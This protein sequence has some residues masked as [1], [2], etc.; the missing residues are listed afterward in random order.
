[1]GQENVDR[2]RAVYSEWAEGNFRA[3]GELLAPESV[4]E[5]MSDGR[6]SYRGREAVERQMRDFLA[7]WSEFRVEA[8]EFVEV[9]EAVLVTERQYAKGRSSDIQVEMTFYA[10]WTFRDGLVVR[11]RWESDR[12]E[13]LKVA[14]LAA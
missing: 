4:Y 11:V 1:M 10:A 14:R 2:L 5:P 9:G 13:A 7:Q 6:E 12:A 3:G 8:R